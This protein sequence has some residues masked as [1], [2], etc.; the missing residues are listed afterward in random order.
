MKPKY[1]I[2]L[3]GEERDLLILSQIGRFQDC[4]VIKE[5]SRFYLIL[6]DFD[7][8]YTNFNSLELLNKFYDLGCQKLEKIN[9]F[10]NFLYGTTREIVPETIYQ[11]QE[12]GSR[13]GL[14]KLYSNLVLESVL[15]P[16]LEAQARNFKKWFEIQE[17]RK[18]YDVLKLFKNQNLGN[19]YWVHLYIIYEKIKNEVGEI[20]IHQNGWSTKAEI[21]LFK[22]TSQCFRHDHDSNFNPPRNP[23]PL[24]EARLLIGKIIQ[25]WL[26]EKCN[27]KS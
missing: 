15:I 12:D 17:N 1:L 14:T 21:K 7:S 22:H 13:V 23:M 9:L 19:L 2:Q 25:H 6:T 10:F 24:Q 27:Q 8:I 16:D 20:N 18:I 4:Q 5:D 11:V 3:Q 26:D